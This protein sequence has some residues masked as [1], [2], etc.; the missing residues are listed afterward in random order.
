MLPTPK[1]GPVLS[2]AVFGNQLEVAQYLLENGAN[3]ESKIV[4]YTTGSQFSS[5]GFALL[6][7]KAEMAALLTRFGAAPVETQGT[8]TSAGAA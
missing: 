3:V 7:E 1:H 4:N 2:Y 5:L 6:Q 8:V